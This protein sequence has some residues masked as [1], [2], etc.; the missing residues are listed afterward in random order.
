MERQYNLLLSASKTVGNFYENVYSPVLQALPWLD[1]ND[2][3]RSASEKVLGNLAFVAYDLSV[4]KQ[5]NENQQS[6]KGLRA[7]RKELESIYQKMQDELQPL[8]E[9]APDQ[10]GT[11][12]KLQGMAVEWK[13]LSHHNLL[14]HRLHKAVE[15]YSGQRTKDEGELGISAGEAVL[16]KLMAEEIKSLIKKGESDHSIALEFGAEGHW[17]DRAF[18]HTLRSMQMT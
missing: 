1:K 11:W 4:Y 9:M 5:Q 8:L 2:G 17:L 14:P 13:E 6:I 18:L 7:R 16:A 12:E 15:N 10:D 3:L